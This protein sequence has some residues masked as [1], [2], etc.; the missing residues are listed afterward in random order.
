MNDYFGTMEV[1][2]RPLRNAGV[3][4]EE[5][6]INDYA[7]LTFNELLSLTKNAIAVHNS[8]IMMEEAT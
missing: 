3:T 1:F 8:K 4:K 5:F 2:E 6:D 7:G